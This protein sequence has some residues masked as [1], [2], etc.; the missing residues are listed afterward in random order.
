MTPLVALALIEAL[1]LHHPLAAAIWA[2]RVCWYAHRFLS[3][4]RL[5]MLTRLLPVN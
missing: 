3:G 2:L 5:K 4:G 1:A